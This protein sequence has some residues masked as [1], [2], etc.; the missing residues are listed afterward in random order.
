MN[1]VISVSAKRTAQFLSVMVVCFTILGWVTQYEAL[2]SSP[3]DFSSDDAHGIVRL[4]YL[5]G[6]ANIPTWYKSATLLICSGL[7]FMIAAA[8]KRA[9]AAFVLYWRDLGIIFLFL[10]IDEIASIHEGLGVQLSHLFEAKGVL[11]FAWVIAGSAIV[12]SILVAYSKFLRS[13]P[14]MATYLFLLSGGIYVGG[15][16]G[17]KM[18]EGWYYTLYGQKTLMFMTIVVVQQLFEMVG[19]VIFIYSLL[20][21]MRFNVNVGVIRVRE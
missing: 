11:Y 16:I 17:V 14:V 1:L 20:S 15:V 8:R 10:S 19:I 18:L 21:Y 5:G 13:L 2:V 12:I 9:Q 6:E 3:E 7:L 4:F